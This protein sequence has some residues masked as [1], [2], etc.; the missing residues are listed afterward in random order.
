MTHDYLC[1]FTDIVL[2]EGEKKDTKIHTLYDSIYMTFKKRHDD[3]MRLRAELGL[4][5]L[6]CC[7][8]ERMGRH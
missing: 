8:G 7:L 5:L 3:S 2:S 1:E 6:G 4:P